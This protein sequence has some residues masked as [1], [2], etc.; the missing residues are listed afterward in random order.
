MKVHERSSCLS[1]EYQTDDDDSSARAGERLAEVDL[2][3]IAEFGR[4]LMRRPPVANLSHRDALGLCLRHAL[5]YLR[6]TTEPVVPGS[7]LTYSRVKERLG[8]ILD[9][10]Y[11]TMQAEMQTV[12]HRSA[13]AAKAKAALGQFGG[14]DDDEDAGDAEHG[15]QAAPMYVPAGATAEYMGSGGRLGMPLAGAPPILIGAGFAADGSGGYAFHDPAVHAYVPSP[16]SLPLPPTPPLP[17]LQQQQQSFPRPVE[18]TTEGN[19]NSP[20]LE[21]GSTMQQGAAVQPPTMPQSPQQPPLLGS[22]PRGGG[23]GGRSGGRGGYYGNGQ[24]GGGRAPYGGGMRGGGGGGGRGGGGRYGGRGHDQQQ[25]SA[26]ISN[27]STGGGYQQSRDGGG[28]GR[29]AFRGSSGGRG[30]SGPRGGS[31][32][33]SV[34]IDG[35]SG[36]TGDNAAPSNATPLQPDTA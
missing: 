3:Q 29:G 9:S 21:D 26:Q 1:Y 31:A 8:R 19:G 18:D 10:D 5:A 22:G 12:S 4:L 35:N 34:G 30:P 17:P 16:P 6:N 15:G 11:F 28:R 13:A 23:G 7:S 24:R 27:S 32:S 36:S 20:V 25:Q 14:D 2:D 33:R